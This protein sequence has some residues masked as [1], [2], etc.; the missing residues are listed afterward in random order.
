MPLLAR[1]TPYLGNVVPVI[2]YIND[3]RREIAAFFANGTAASQATAQSFTSSRIAHYLRISSP[4]N[5]ET[6]TAYAARPDSNRSNPYLTPGGYLDLLNGLPLFGGYLCT[7]NTLPTIGAD[8]T[9]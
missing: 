5:P 4:V 1:L 9:R 8:D 3:Y 6:L 2:N 7:N